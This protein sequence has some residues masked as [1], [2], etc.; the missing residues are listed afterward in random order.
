MGEREAGTE[1]IARNDPTMGLVEIR[2]VDGSTRAA[3]NA[4]YADVGIRHPDRLWEW[5]LDLIDARAGMRLLDVACGEAEMVRHAAARGLEAHGV[6]LSEVALRTGRSAAARRGEPAIGLHAA[7][8]EALPFPD[9]CFDR[10][11][12]MG[13]LEH[14]ED[15]VQGAAEMARVLAD[16]GLVCLHVPNTFGLRWNVLH[17]WRSGDVADDGQPIQ[18]YGTRAQWTR[19]LEAGGL[20][21][22]QVLGY[23]EL[24]HLPV[25]LSGWLGAL[26]HPSR[27]M[28][29]LARW[30]PRD[31]ASILLFVCRRADAA[32]RSNSGFDVDVALDPDPD[33]ALDPVPDVA[34]DPEVDDPGISEFERLRADAPDAFDI[35]LDLSWGRKEFEHWRSIGA[36]QPKRPGEVILVVRR[37]DGDVLLHTK[38]F[39]PI[40]AWRLLTGGLEGDESLELAVARELAEETGLVERSRRYLGRLCSTFGHD[41][42]TISFTSY[43][44]LIDVGPAPAPRPLDDSEQISAFRWSSPEALR[45]V[46]ESLRSRTDEWSDWGAF[47]AAAHDAVADALADAPAE[48]FAETLA[49]TPTD[50]PG[51]TLADAPADVPDDTLSDTLADAPAA[52]LS[53]QRPEAMKRKKT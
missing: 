36:G 49:E 3:Y 43:A 9:R 40:G 7:N 1:R 8:G 19:V 27:L 20:E 26:R 42:E 15:P 29:P 12:N 46:A 31:M 21:V 23:E 24:A 45:A 47:R 44:F 37:D 18:R 51:V 22:V 16:D 6:D 4:I 10:V 33:I 41:G 30:L 53:A 13:S 25:G 11:T 28:V 38:A 34:P 14:Y 48:T 5:I 2:H 35:Q 52:P 50:A 32:P 39:Y 17:A